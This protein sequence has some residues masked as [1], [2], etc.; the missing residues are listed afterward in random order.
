MNMQVY[1]KIIEASGRGRFNVN[2]ASE[3]LG[4]AG[5][6]VLIFAAGIAVWDVYTSDNK[7]HRKLFK[8]YE[9]LPAGQSE[10]TPPPP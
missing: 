7:Q 6:G 4:A 5:M 9:T 2:L 10:S 3:V 8:L 1:N